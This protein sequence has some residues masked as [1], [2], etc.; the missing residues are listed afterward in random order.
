MGYTEKWRLNARDLEEERN[1]NEM[2]MELKINNTELEYMLKVVQDD[3][4]KLAENM[5]HL[6]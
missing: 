1:E 2:E 6:M 4:D 3:M 5:E